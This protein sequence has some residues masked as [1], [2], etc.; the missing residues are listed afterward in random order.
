MPMAT[1]PDDKPQPPALPDALT[2]PRPVIAVIAL[3]WLVAV[4]LSFMVPA[5]ESWRPI[6]VAG[7]GLTAFGTS[8]FLW[9]RHASRRGSRGAQTGLR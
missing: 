4:V 1:E 8:V 6:A 5:L 7:L 2:D 3:G 9:Q